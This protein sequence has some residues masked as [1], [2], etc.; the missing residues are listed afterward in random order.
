MEDINDS[1][2]ELGFPNSFCIYFLLY[3]SFLK[4]LYNNFY[5]NKCAIYVTYVLY[6]AYFILDKTKI[7]KL[8]KKGGGSI[9]G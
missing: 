4:Y 9:N 5:K 7:H 1:L 8:E 6:L 2:K 3:Q